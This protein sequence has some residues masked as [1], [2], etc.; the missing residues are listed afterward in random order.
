MNILDRIVRR[1]GLGRQSVP[2]PF[3]NAFADPKPQHDTAAPSL[4][5]RRSAFSRGL[6]SEEQRAAVWAKAQPII[7]W[8]PNDWR[9]DHLGNPLFRGH[10]GDASSSFGWEI[11]HIH[12]PLDA[13]EDLANLRPQRCRAEKPGYR[14]AAPLDTAT[15]G[16]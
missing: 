2:P 9:V 4:P 12:E 5:F 10:Y 11:G 16:R 14:F 1:I 15:L 8:D 13:R 6:Y 3:V 7:G